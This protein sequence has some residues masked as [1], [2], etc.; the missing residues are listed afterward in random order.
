MCRYGDACICCVDT[1]PTGWRDA[2]SWSSWWPFERLGPIEGRRC[3]EAASRRFLPR[4][5]PLKS[6]FGY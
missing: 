4:G 2:I 5:L 3:C 1:L 6:V